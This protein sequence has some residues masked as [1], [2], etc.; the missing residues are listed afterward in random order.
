MADGGRVS[1]G[2]S[3]VTAREK[4][5]VKPMDDVSPIQCDMDAYP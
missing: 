3:T 4:T 5:A 2:V 1:K